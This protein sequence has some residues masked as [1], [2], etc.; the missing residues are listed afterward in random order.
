V[1]LAEKVSLQEH[2][3]PALQTAAGFRA[4]VFA[5]AA[6]THIELKSLIGQPALIELE[7]ADASLRPWHGHITQA[8]LVGSDGGLARYR[9]VIE[10]WLSFLGARQ[11]SWVFQG[12][13]VKD[14]IE[15]VFADYQA[16]GKL[17]PAYRWSLADE[18]VYAERSLCIQYQETDLAFVKR[19]LLEEGLYCWWEHEAGAGEKPG[20]HTLVTADRD[21]AVRAVFG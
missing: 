2:I 21:G 4:E 15:E 3:G 19:L 8:A 9:L 7:L 18:A 17:A 10:P 11:D 6:D 20:T 12:Q 16:Q 5:L 14:I 1:L 13:S